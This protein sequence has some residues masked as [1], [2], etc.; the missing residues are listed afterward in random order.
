[1]L[2]DEIKTA[3]A[4]MG[5]KPVKRDG[6]WL[7]DGGL[8][9]PAPISL[10]HAMGADTIVAVNLNESGSHVSAPVAGKVKRKLGLMFDR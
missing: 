6:A 8:V 5:I 2:M 10:C 4:E 9:N 7:V 1:M 3:G